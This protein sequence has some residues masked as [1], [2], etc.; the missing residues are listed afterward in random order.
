MGDLLNLLPNVSSWK[1]GEDVALLE[2]MQGLASSM[3]TSSKQLQERIDRLARETERAHTRL[4]T[5]QNNFVHLSNVK[6]IEA[7]VYEDSEEAVDDQAV[8]ANDETPTEETLI[9]EALGCGAKLLEVAFEKVDIEDSDSDDEEEEGAKIISVMQPKNPFHIRSLPAVVGSKAWL[10]DDKIGL[11]EEEEAEEAELSECSDE[12]EV[13]QGVEKD[14]DSEFSQSDEEET[15]SKPTTKILPPTVKQSVVDDSD[16]EFSDDDDDELFKPKPAPP[17]TSPKVE[18]GQDHTKSLTTRDGEN[19]SQETDEEMEEPSESKS[20]FSQELSKKLGLA[21]PDP[22]QGEEGDNTDGDANEQSPK[23]TQ[24]IKKSLLF[25]SSDSEDDLF[26]GKP[27]LPKKAA[28]P[29]PSPGA[30]KV[31]EKAPPPPPPSSEKPK[32]T[33]KE[34]EPEQKS[35][36][37]PPTSLEK[38]VPARK[39]LFGSSS[40]DEDDIFA[41]LTA[42]APAP[43][44][45]IVAVDSDDSDDDIFAPRPN[46]SAAK[47]EEHINFDNDGKPSSPVAKKPF[48]GISMFGSGFNPTSALKT[49]QTSSDPTSVKSEDEEEEEDDIFNPASARPSPPSRAYEDDVEEVK[50]PQQAPDKAA[51][52]AETEEHEKTTPDRVNEGEIEISF[53]PALGLTAKTSATKEDDTTDSGAA[54]NPP[55]GDLPVLTT[56]TKSRSRGSAGRRPPSRSARK[57]A[58]ESASEAVDQE[59]EADESSSSKG[60]EA[61]TAGISSKTDDD[62][63]PAVKKP[64]GGISMFGAGFNPSAAL[65]S[66]KSRNE[67]METKSQDEVGAIEV[68]TREENG[69]REEDDMLLGK[70]ETILEGTNYSGEQSDTKV[71][72]PDLFGGADDDDDDDG[73]FGQTPTKG[74]LVLDA[75]EEQGQ[76]PVSEMPSKVSGLFDDDEDDDDFFNAPP[77]LEG[78]SDKGQAKK[79]IFGF[80]EDDSDDDLFSNMAS[81][82]KPSLKPNPLANILGDDSDDDLFSS[83]IPKSTK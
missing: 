45:A 41:N 21:P 50:L 25:D 35:Q 55:A 37:E 36:I 68:T 75:K 24:P 76:E 12:E 26:S 18:N 30:E 42:K 61:T 15:Q 65:R 71:S 64:I 80:D 7:R 31:M 38:D 62:E 60:N 52:E 81:G 46:A 66:M 28:K 49:E 78:S 23:K 13:D 14:D 67:D 59:D 74:G 43:K 33:V 47:E 11:V 48:G 8:K 32:E 34:V 5:T 79:D 40:E 29:K 1:L 9:S 10:D 44:S 54:L 19:Q 72:P 6:F 69:A 63:L 51:H 77:K 70:E 83:L 16:S 17:V 58:V 20:T 56:L 73:L 39:P 22:K 57:K 2:A 53:P 4:L 82:V 27:A 3:G